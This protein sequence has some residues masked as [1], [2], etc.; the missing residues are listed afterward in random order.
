MFNSILLA[1]LLLSIGLFFWAIYK[2]I[3]TQQP[4][5]AWGLL[6]FFLFIGL[7]FIR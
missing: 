6:P 5:Y 4:K 1:L 7:M 2:A 3:K